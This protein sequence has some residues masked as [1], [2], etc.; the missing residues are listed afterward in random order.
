MVELCTSAYKK[1]GQLSQALWQ[2][3]LKP[4]VCSNHD[5]SGKEP[6]ESPAPSL[7]LCMYDKQSSTLNTLQI[8]SCSSA[9]KKLKQK[10]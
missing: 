9:R 2:L 8:S 10:A 1:V 4:A 6:R 3:S 7:L 5:D